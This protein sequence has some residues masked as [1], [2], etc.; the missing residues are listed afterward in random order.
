MELEKPNF[1]SNLS[2]LLHFDCRTASRHHHQSDIL[3]S[4]VVESSQVYIFLDLEI[5]CN[6][7]S[8]IMGHKSSKSLNHQKIQNIKFNF[9]FAVW[10]T[11]VDKTLC[12]KQ[13]HFYA[14][15]LIQFARFSDTLLTL[16][17]ITLFNMFK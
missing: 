12:V 6:R 15:I 7:S 13:K 8:G 9:S 5:N 14:Y 4:N 1:S 2:D 16:N 10:F 17:Y 3:C 11:A